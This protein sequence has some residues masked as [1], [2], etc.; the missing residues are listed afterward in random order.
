MIVPISY[1]LIALTP[2]CLASL[3]CPR[4]VLRAHAVFLSGRRSNGTLRRPP[5][6]V[7]VTS[8]DV[9]TLLNIVSESMLQ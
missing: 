3:E 4:M 6:R 8:L 7:F 2:K 5:A 9:F 1:F